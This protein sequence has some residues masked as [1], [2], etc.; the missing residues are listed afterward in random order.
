MVDKLLSGNE[1]LL[2]WCAVLGSYLSSPLHLELTSLRNERA[3]KGVKKKEKKKER[4]RERDLS[5]FQ[6]D[7]TDSFT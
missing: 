6:L 5:T 3:R 1:I 7:K 2:R 4:K